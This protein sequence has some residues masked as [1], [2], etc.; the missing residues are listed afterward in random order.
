[1][2]ACF[3]SGILIV[4]IASSVFADTVV[5][6][7]TNSK[8]LVVTEVSQETIQVKV[9]VKTASGSWVTA[10]DITEAAHN[11]S[12]HAQQ[13]ATNPI[14]ADCNGNGIDDAADIASGAASDIDGDGR[15]DSC[16]IR[17]GD[18]NLDGVVNGMDVNVVLGWWNLGYS[19]TADVTGDGTID[20]NDLA[21]VLAAWGTHPS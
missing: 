15:P 17:A 1:M 10:A 21:A 7:Q 14:T 12:D 2:K 8:K 13:A 19:P 11:A 4:S 20:G 9:Q 5:K 18:V 16:E 6:G 3:F